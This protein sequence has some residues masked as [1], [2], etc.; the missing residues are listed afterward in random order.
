MEAPSEDRFSDLPNP[1]IHHIFS[2]L[3]T[4]DIPRIAAVSRRFRDVCSSSPYLDLEADFLASQNCESDCQGFKDFVNRVLAHRNGVGIHRLRLSWFCN[5]PHY[6]GLAG[7]VI[8]NWVKYAAECNVQELEIGLFPGDGALFV[9][10][11]CL[12][13][14]QSLREL[15]LN[16]KGRGLV[17]QPGVFASLVELT[18][19]NVELCATFS[20]GGI[21]TWISTACKS[22]KNLF[23]YKV[24][25]SRSK[26]MSISSSSLQHLNLC[27]CEFPEGSKLSITSASLQHLSMRRCVFNEQGK[28]VVRAERL[29]NLLVDVDF[30]SDFPYRLDYQLFKFRIFAPSLVSFSWR[31]PPASYSDNLEHFLCLDEASI[32]LNFQQHDEEFAPHNQQ[33][34][35]FALGF[36]EQMLHRVRY[37]RTLKL[38]TEIF[39][40]YHQPGVFDNLKHLVV[41][42]PRFEEDQDQTISPFLSGLRNLRTLTLKLDDDNNGEVDANVVAL[43]WMRRQRYVAKKRK[44][45]RIAFCFND[46]EQ[47]GPREKDNEAMLKWIL[48]CEKALEKV[49]FYY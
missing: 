49:V 32:S 17:L 42:G 19:A 23:L 1:V 39:V 41:V 25:C 31:G 20:G 13:N 6:K 48:E 30:S 9:I 11:P 33:D 5:Q 18:L 22:L 38:N 4:N 3:E 47:V 40:Y 34:V 35:E 36:L 14:C 24:T 27:A 37:T 29:E 45:R 15:T 44:P 10:P 28:V 26:D 2:Y 8:D 43:L 21:G 7:P 16:L 46:N 12:S